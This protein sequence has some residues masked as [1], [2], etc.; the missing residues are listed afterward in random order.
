MFE[1]ERSRR[2]RRRSCTI[3]FLIDRFLNKLVTCAQSSDS[4]GDDP[5]GS[6]VRPKNSLE[7]NWRNDLHRIVKNIGGM[8]KLCGETPSTAAIGNWGVTGECF[9]CAACFPFLAPLSLFI[10]CLLVIPLKIPKK[11]I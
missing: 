8:R 2:R 10:P 1:K 6:Q 5:S 3:S 4:D 7:W 9:A 11:F